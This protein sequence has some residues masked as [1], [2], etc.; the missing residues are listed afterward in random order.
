MVLGVL[1]AAKDMHRK[2]VRDDDPINACITS[3]E[4]RIQRYKIYTK[5]RFDC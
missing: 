5:L 4:Y 2:C 1:R 3:P